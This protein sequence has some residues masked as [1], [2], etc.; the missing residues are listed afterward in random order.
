ML[1]LVLLFTLC[2]EEVTWQVSI[3]LLSCS[4]IILFL[5]IC[6]WIRIT[7]SVPRTTK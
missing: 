3:P 1:T 5:L 6:S 7:F 2:V 4:T